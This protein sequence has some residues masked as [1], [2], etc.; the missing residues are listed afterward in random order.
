MT[1]GRG[2]AP[3]A[4]RLGHEVPGRVAVVLGRQ[5][6]RVHV[7]H[8]TADVV[9][10]LHGGVAVGLQVS[11]RQRW[12]VVVGQLGR[13]LGQLVGVDHQGLLGMVRPGA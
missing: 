1:P 10:G 2:E 5:Q 8:V 6:G 7:L 3:P 13:Q 12:G 9:G 11:V 4:H